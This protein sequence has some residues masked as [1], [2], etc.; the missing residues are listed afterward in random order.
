MVGSPPLRNVTTSFANDL[1]SVGALVLKLPPDILSPFVHRVSNIKTTHSVDTSVPA[2]ALRTFITSFTPPLPGVVPSVKTQDAYSAISR[3]LI[4][5][6]LGY[7][8]IPHGMDNLPAPPP[9]MLELGSEKGVNS[10]AVDVLTEVIRCFGPILDE[11]EKK[12]LQKT[13]LAILEDER[14]NSVIKKK[15]VVSLSLL[16]V[17]MPDRLLNTLVSNLTDSFRNQNLTLPRRRLLINVV[18]SL[19][20]L[21]PHRIGAHLKTLAP[22]VLTSLSQDAFAEYESHVV[23]DGSI[24]PEVEEVREAALVALEGFLS[25]CS[26]EMRPFTNDAIECSLRFLGYDPMA[27]MTEDDEEMG[28]TQDE[29]EGDELDC[30]QDYDADEDFE[31]EG[32]LS[33]DDDSSWK[34]RRCAA[35]NLYAIISTRSNGDLL[36]NGTLYEKVAPVLISRFKEREE[37]VRLEILATL[38]SLVRKTAEGLPILEIGSIKETELNLEHAQR[39]R[40]RRRVDSNASFDATAAFTSTVGLMSP[41][42]SPSPVSGPKADLAQLSPTIVR[43][44]G[45]L[46]RQSSVP[47]KQA[48]VTL[49]RDMVLV[50][51]GGLS[52]LFGKIVD[53]LI[54]AVK[55]SGSSVNSVT[56]SSIGGAAAAS[57]SRMRIEALQL[58]SA[59]FDTH[60][61]K[62]LSPYIGVIFPGVIASIGDKYYKVS[63]EALLTAESIIKALTPPRSAGS[64]QERKTYLEEVYEAVLPR[65]VAADADLEVRQQSIHALGVLLARTS[66]SPRLLPGEKRAKILTAMQERLKN[67]TTR[68]A[69]IKSVDLVIASA[70][71]SSDLPAQWIKQVT[72]ELAAQLRKADRGL[73]GASLSALRNLVSKRITLKLLDDETI[74]SLSEMLLPLLVSGDVSMIGMTFTCFSRL[75]KKNP[76]KV[77][78]TDLNQVLCKVILTPCIAAVSEQF[79]Q[80]I[81]NIGESGHGQPLMQ[82]FLQQVGV[83]GDT[84]IVGK[85]IGTLLVS[86][87]KSL[88]VGLEDFVGELQSSKDPQRKSLALSILGEA[89]L[90]LGSSSPLEPQ[91]FS[92]HFNSK[93]DA[94]PRAAAIALGRAGAGNIPHFLPFIL[95][96]AGK[97][98]QLQ[99]LSLHSIKEILQLSSKAHSDVLPYTKEIWGKLLQASQTEDSKIIGAECIGRITIIEPKTFLPTLQVSHTR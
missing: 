17:H 27:A 62:I 97:S 78:N 73:R 76:R 30:V 47:T 92:T 55:G 18:G 8:V 60:S 53:P 10:D 71:E 11:R 13:I 63:S 69:A 34:I 46:M 68:L 67:E 16:A 54:E 14:S 75:V 12:A 31:E 66:G 24:I 61:S 5:R 33:D 83:S 26:K 96:N 40:K 51:N 20:R 35:K 74:Q 37:N 50:L 57:G 80:L 90:R 9:G 42:A 58:V 3:V 52:E 95:T 79:L 70:S 48:A 49:L 21:I 29:D 2:T 64:D 87:G 99:Y 6:L 44:I 36:D 77:V 65:S 23:E 98:G 93:S 82:G 32:A 94:V 45:K 72:L 59:V 7:I 41:A 19:S 86:G 56:S 88:G 4:P 15:A 84:A 22:L 1:C 43:G 85:A 25:S 91:L 28:G 38:D 89:G 39:S 81:R